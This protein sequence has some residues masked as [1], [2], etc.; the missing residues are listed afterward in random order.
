MKVFYFRTCILSILLFQQQKFGVNCLDPTSSRALACY[1]HQDCQNGT[2][3][4][5]SACPSVNGLTYACGICKSCAD[6]V[7]NRDS[8]DYV[9]PTYQCPD[10]PTEG[11]RFLQGLF[12]NSSEIKSAPGYTCFLKITISGNMFSILQIPVYTLH[13][14]TTATLIDAAAL[15]PECPSI[16]RSGV[17]HTPNQ[18][19]GPD[20]LVNVT[21]LSQGLPASMMHWTLFPPTRSIRS[22][23]D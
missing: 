23:S 1:R 4:G 15:E 2:F 21:V 17:L 12:L 3:C 16:S 20:L 18:V 5:W 8:V 14:A 13:P 19:A 6:C 22:V 7:C 9:C 11:I 10:S